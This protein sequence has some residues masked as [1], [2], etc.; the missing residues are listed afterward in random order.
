[1]TEP[2]E[3]VDPE[4]PERATGVKEAVELAGPVSPALVAEDWLLVVPESPVRAV[5]V[6]AALTSPPLPLSVSARGSGRA[7]VVPTACMPAMA[8]E[9]VPAWPGTALEA[10][11][12]LP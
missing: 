3:P 8:L 6:P 2:V 4:S 11:P 10:P 1:M 12:M 5:G 7:C 9:A